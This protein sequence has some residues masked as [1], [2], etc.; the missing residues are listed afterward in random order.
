[1]VHFFDFIASGVFSKQINPKRTAHSLKKHKF[2][3][4]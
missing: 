1:M 4:S 3:K 2:V